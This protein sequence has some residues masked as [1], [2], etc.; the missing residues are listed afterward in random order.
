MTAYQFSR[1]GSAAMPRTRGRR[2]SALLGTGVGTLVPSCLNGL[3]HGLAPRRGVRIPLRP[4][5]WRSARDAVRPGHRASTRNHKRSDAGTI[6]DA[7]ATIRDDAAT[8]EDDAATIGDDAG[9]IGDDARTIGDD[10]RTIGDA[11]RTIED[12]ASEYVKV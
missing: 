4:I 8:I 12:A 11:V 2:F 7:A 6:E 5:H 1:W 3:P 9:T 10:V